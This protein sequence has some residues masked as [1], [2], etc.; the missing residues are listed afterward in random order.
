MGL[1]ARGL[2][3]LLMLLFTLQAL[4]LAAHA[5]DAHPHAHEIVAAALD[6]PHPDTD[7]AHHC[8]HHLCFHVLASSHSA[9]APEIPIATHPAPPLV[10]ISHP[11][12]SPFR[13][14]QV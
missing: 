7:N 14:P 3:I 2:K 10:S 13:P 5:H 6:N 1:L 12:A 8:C 9:V 11:Q 4:T